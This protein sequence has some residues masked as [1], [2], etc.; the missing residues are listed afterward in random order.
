MA[1]EFTEK[2]DAAL[3][4]WTVLDHLQKLNNLQP[5]D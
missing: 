1:E 2:I 4:E 5:P 3:A